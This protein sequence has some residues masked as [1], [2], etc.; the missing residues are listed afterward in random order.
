M[1]D[2][3]GYLERKGRAL[4]KCCICWSALENESSLRVGMG[5][6]CQKKFLEAQKRRAE[7][8]LNTIPT[9]ADGMNLAQQSADANDNDDDDGNDNHDNE[10]DEDNDEEEK[11][12]KKA[13]KIKISN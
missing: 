1:Q 12:T 8:S 11:E 7:E 6:T 3:V 9:T 4:G 2:P 13:K 10:D 5:P